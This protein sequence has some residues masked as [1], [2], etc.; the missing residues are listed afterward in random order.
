MIETIKGA[1]GGMGKVK[2]NTIWTKSF[3]L[4]IVINFLGCLV[5]MMTTPLVLEY[6]KEIGAGLTLASAACKYDVI[7]IF[8]GVS[9]CGIYFG[10]L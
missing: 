4:V 9:V 7:C 2:E 10:L 8:A 1:H 5:G 3:M 6:A